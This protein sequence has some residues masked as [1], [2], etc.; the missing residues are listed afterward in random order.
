MKASH[1]R[2][3]VRRESVTKT[4][5]AHLFV[6]VHDFYAL[7]ARSKSRAKVSGFSCKCEN[8]G[9]DNSFLYAVA[10]QRVPAGASQLAR[11]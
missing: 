1:T 7:S 9:E 6:V 8:K 10:Q 3:I 5:A 11:A 2:D 4:K